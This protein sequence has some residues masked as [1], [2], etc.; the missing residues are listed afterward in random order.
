[1]TDLNSWAPKHTWEGQW[2]FPGE[3]TFGMLAAVRHA[4]LDSIDIPEQHDTMSSIATPYT[5]QLTY[6]PRVHQ[7]RSKVQHYKKLFLFIFKNILPLLNSCF[8]NTLNLHVHIKT[9]KA[10]NNTK[11]YCWNFCTLIIHKNIMIKIEW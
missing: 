7:R 10:T 11:I 8:N 9:M 3:G 6:Q 5:Q 4:P 1:M 2:I